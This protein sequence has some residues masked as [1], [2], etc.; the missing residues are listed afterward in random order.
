MESFDNPNGKFGDNLGNAAII[1]CKYI[2]EL[3]ED[4][5]SQFMDFLRDMPQ[6]DFCNYA[7]SIAGVIK[8]QVSIYTRGYKN[9]ITKL[10]VSGDELID[11]ITFDANITA[12]TPL[13]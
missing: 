8:D 12:S 13:Q 4:K 11:T 3:F 7:M 2:D 6:V 9:M 5:T 1:D 10:A